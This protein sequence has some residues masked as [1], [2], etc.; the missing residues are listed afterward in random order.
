MN[1]LVAAGGT[2][3]PIDDV[4]QIA[5]ASTGRLGAAIAEA[6]LAR[7]AEVWHSPTPSALRPFERLARF[8]LDAPDPAVEFA[9][10][11]ALRLDW[12]AVRDR[13]HPVPLPSGTVPEYAEALEPTL[14]NHPI[15]VA[16]L[17]IAASDYAP[18]PTAGKL[19][20]DRS[21]LTIHCRQLPKVIR[22]VRDWSP[23]AYLVGFK[24]LSNAPHAD[25]I[26][27]AEQACRAN[28]ADLT[29]AN[30]LATVRAGAHAST[31]SAPAV[32]SRRSA[33]GRPS[34]PTWSIGSSPGPTFSPGSGRGKSTRSAVDR[35][36]RPRRAGAP[37]I[38]RGSR[39]SP[40]RS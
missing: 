28:R 35:C 14:R 5:N 12:L 39:P 27:Q 19:A 4:R 29:V 38:D 21:E 2:V 34:P 8:D 1:V 18:D 32:R 26:R 23:R 13:L 7:G 33:P 22:S 9:R 40:F 3:A 15:D 36:G 17:P 11:A 16:F 20:S 25:L 31:S 37:K 6:A 30:D 10:L 24:L